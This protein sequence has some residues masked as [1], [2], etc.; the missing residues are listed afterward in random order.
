MEI[1]TIILILVVVLL[2]MLFFYKAFFGKRGG[3]CLYSM[4]IYYGSCLF[5]LLFWGLIGL[6]IYWAIIY[7]EII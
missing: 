4:G 3:G 1:S 5:V 7:W 6:C 2:A